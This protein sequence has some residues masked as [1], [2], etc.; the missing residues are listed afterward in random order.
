M[1]RVNNFQERLKVAT[2]AHS[3]TLGQKDLEI[4]KLK[5]ELEKQRDENRVLKD[6]NSVSQH[7]YDSQNSIISKLKGQMTDKDQ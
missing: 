1:E 3:A 6:D 5:E 2:E 7:Q 4:A